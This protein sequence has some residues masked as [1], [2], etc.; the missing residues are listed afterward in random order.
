MC[1][2]VQF[3]PL[4]DEIFI[5]GHSQVEPSMHNSKM[6]KQYLAELLNLGCNCGEGCLFYSGWVSGTKTL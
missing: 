5:S 2:P 1:F 3:C 6:A 4:F